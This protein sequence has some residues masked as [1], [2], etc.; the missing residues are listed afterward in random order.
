MGGW[1]GVGGWVVE[2]KL[3]DRLWLSFSLALAKPNKNAQLIPYASL[4]SSS[5]QAGYRD[6]LCSLGPSGQ[7]GLPLY[8]A[9]ISMATFSRAM[10]TGCD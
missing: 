5:T 7:S 9:P 10:N 2:S 6:H 4:G 8:I 1:V 3:S